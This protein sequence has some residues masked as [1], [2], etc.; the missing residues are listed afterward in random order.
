MMRRTKRSAYA[1]RFADMRK[2]ISARRKIVRSGCV[3]H[4]GKLRCASASSSNRYTAAPTEFFK[5]AEKA[6]EIGLAQ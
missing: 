1:F 2:I 6:V 3:E 5:H 4:W